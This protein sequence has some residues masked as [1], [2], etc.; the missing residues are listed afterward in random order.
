MHL[1][2]G[3]EEIFIFHCLFTIM[4][5][6]L[7]KYILQLTRYMPTL[8]VLTFIVLLWNLIIHLA[9]LGRTRRNLLLAQLTSET[10][11]NAYLE[12][13][14]IDNAT[15]KDRWYPLYEIDS[16][17]K[18][19]SDVVG[20]KSESSDNHSLH[21]VF[22]FHPFMYTMVPRN[23]CEDEGV[24]LLLLIYV[25]SAPFNH[26]RRMLIRNTWGNPYN[27][28]SIKTQVN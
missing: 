10:R 6:A 28:P 14:S 1:H 24:N 23:V 26:K 11:M 9:L 15:V 21:G 13:R 3:F 8:I 7:K 27:V 19:L 25:H 16:A 18:K 17:A 12:N 20:M 5:V 4:V 22:G 2:A